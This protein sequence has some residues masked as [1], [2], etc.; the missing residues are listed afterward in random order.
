MVQRLSDVGHEILDVLKTNGQTKQTVADPVALALVGRIG[1]VGHAGRVLN[2]GFGI[3]E[4]D[5]ADNQFEPIHEGHAG[6]DA[7][8]ELERNEPARL[9]HLAL[10]KLVLGKRLEAG[11]SETCDTSG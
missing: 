11:I 1:R 2:Q 10:R 8:L 6:F 5:C 7:P 9:S 4:A 3:A